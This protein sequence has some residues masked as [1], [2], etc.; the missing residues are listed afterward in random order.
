MDFY[1]RTEPTEEGKRVDTHGVDWGPGGML[2]IYRNG[3]Y[4]LGK[5]PS[6]TTWLSMFNPSAYVPTAYDIIKFEE[7]DEEHGRG[8]FKAETIIHSQPGHGWRKEVE[9]LKSTVDILEK[10]RQSGEQI[11]SITQARELWR[12]VADSGN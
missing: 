8:Y 9:A 3:N 11:Q 10:L 7:H 1:I 2:L 4:L 6:H 12:E 5:V